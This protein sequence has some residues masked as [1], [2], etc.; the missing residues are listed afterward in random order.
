[1]FFSEQ[2][3]AAAASG[4][5]AINCNAANRAL[6]AVSSV[7]LHYRLDFQRILAFV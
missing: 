1:M 5:S 3:S 2:I 7:T 4:T 6:I